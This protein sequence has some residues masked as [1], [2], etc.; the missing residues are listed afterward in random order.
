MAWLEFY[1]LL[2]AGLFGPMETVGFRKFS[3]NISG[4][5]LN[6]RNAKTYIRFMDMA[7]VRESPAS[8][9]AENKVHETLHFR[10]LKCLV[11][12]IFVESP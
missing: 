1:V 8:K 4:R 5:Y 9:T 11:K 10:Y 7:Y 2:M 12:C 3:P 6:W